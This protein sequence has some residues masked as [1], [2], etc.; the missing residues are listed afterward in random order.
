MTLT[1]ASMG[2]PWD[3]LVPLRLRI[4][5]THRCCTK[6]G[7][8]PY[9]TRDMA[10]NACGTCSRRCG[11]HVVA[12]LGAPTYHHLTC[13]RMDTADIT[14]ILPSAH[15][16]PSSNTLHLPSGRLR[17]PLMHNAAPT[18]CTRP[19]LGR[20]QL[21]P[22]LGRCL[23]AC[24]NVVQDQARELD[25]CLDSQRRRRRVQRTLPSSREADKRCAAGTMLPRGPVRSLIC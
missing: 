14:P 6:P 9:H 1:F 10:V 15:P 19:C 25:G 22:K 21:L 8:A 16:L 20:T 12:S 11:S 2:G 18:P 17:L 5:R 4:R 3:T 7:G 13:R 23:N 24:S